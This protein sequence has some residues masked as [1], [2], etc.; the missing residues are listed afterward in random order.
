MSNMDHNRTGNGSRIDPLDKR[1]IVTGAEIKI[2]RTV[3]QQREIRA[4]L[5]GSES[6]LVFKADC[7][8][9]EQKARMPR[10]DV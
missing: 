1:D 8:S 10:E 4:S 9:E 7:Y 3:Y 5:D 6:S 2:R